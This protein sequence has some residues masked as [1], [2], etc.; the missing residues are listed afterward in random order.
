MAVAKS[1]KTRASMMRSWHS[2]CFT[3][4][5]NVMNQERNERKKAIYLSNTSPGYAS[6]NRKGKD[7]WIT[8]S[9][10]IHVSGRMISHFEVFI[11]SFFVDEGQGN[12][13]FQRCGAFN[14]FCVNSDPLFGVLPRINVLAGLSRHL[15]VLASLYHRIVTSGK[16][17]LR[18][19][20]K[21]SNF[22]C[23]F[24]R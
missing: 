17:I 10:L 1:R 23:F 22:A 4:K 9:V 18:K 16:E 19:Q 7:K 8:C 14:N 13:A 15:W 21:M 5:K 11:A 12:R 20:K 6:W 24:Q 2:I 3:E